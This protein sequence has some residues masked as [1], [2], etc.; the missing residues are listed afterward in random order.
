MR[1]EGEYR[2]RLL[3]RILKDMDL[4]QESQ[5]QEALAIQRERGGPIGEIFVERG[6][7]TR[8]DLSL[9][10]ASQSGMEVVN[11]ES[12][13]I[14]ATVV[15]RVSPAI[16]RAYRVIP[17]RFE[18]GVLTVAL[19]DPTLLKT[20]DDL[21]FLLNCELKGAV[22]SEE[23]VN[24]AL[25]THYSQQEDIEQILQEIS[26][27]WGDVPDLTASVS[28][29]ES[30]D[31][32]SLEEMANLAPVRR[33][34]NLVLL[35]AIT[36]RA[37]DIHF[38]PFEDEFKIRYRVDG[39]LYEMVPPPRHLHLAL[40]SRLKAMTNSM[41]I[42]Q[43]RMPQDGRIQLNIS[44]NPVDLRV[45]CLPTMFG[46]SV[47]CRVLDR[48]L[49]ALDIDKLGFRSDDLGSVRE[50]MAKTHG[51]V[52][53]T[54]PTGCGK[55]T[56]L[57]SV[58]RAMN[59]VGVKILTAEDPVE[60]DLE[61]IMQVNVNEEIGVSFS[62]LLRNFVRQDPDIILVGEVRDIETGEI[63]IQA[64]LT[65]HLV[66]STSHTNDAP[67]TVIRLIDLGLEPYL[68]NA[69]LEGIVA[70]R[71][72]RRTCMNC[73]EE[74]EPGVDSVLAVGLRPEDVEGKKFY[75]GRGCELC[76]NI[77]YRGRM[78]VFEVLTMNEELREMLMG[79]I[80]TGELRACARRHGV[81][82]L[83]DSGLLAV[84]DGLTTLEEVARSTLAEV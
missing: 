56:T 74:Y 27:G 10:L 58:L 63:A 5:I 79:D 43:R 84:Y 65:G 57:Y 34:L 25:E 3:G 66:F 29:S 13:D 81:R 12:T 82:S 21:R 45:S 73:K 30:I 76:N 64:S 72:V 68:I 70:Q 32:E 53:C 19:A 16:A 67:T 62:R 49:V 39:V 54:G 23:A 55:T 4:V 40:S 50:L 26:Q 60:Y 42:A 31:L 38:E 2:K 78:G 44:G 61:G 18:D 52:M 47:V 7:V 8:E 9:A 83:R 71:L 20:L 36:E 75:R 22:S 33:L 48:R 51:I 6:Y 35:T 17:V 77:G 37:S 14:P 28:A 24:G 41:D 59:D 1:E 80:S 69:T 15:S 11:L 46:E